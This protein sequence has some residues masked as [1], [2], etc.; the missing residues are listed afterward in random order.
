M[1]GSGFLGNG[2]EGLRTLNTDAPHLAHGRRARAPAGRE[3]RPRARP[4]AA[5][6]V[7]ERPTAGARPRRAAASARA[8]ALPLEV[9]EVPAPARG[10]ARGPQGLLGAQRL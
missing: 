7:S 1:E 8:Q 6:P 3:A 4:R 5:R 9:G 2:S 10:A